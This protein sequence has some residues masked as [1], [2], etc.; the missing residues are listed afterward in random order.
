ML[1][2]YTVLTKLYGKLVLI[3]EKDNAALTGINME[4]L[5]ELLTKSMDVTLL[6]VPGFEDQEVQKKIWSSYNSF[7]LASKVFKEMPEDERLKKQG[8]YLESFTMWL[9]FVT[10]CIND[11]LT[12]REWFPAIRPRYPPYPR[13]CNTIR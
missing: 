4:E 12:Q 9:D 6:M 11:A 10:T 7:G 2:R 1:R 13:G 8:E 5:F 3:A